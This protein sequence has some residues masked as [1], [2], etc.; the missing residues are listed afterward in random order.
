[1]TQEQK[2]QFT[3]RIAEANSTELVVILYEMAL[4][5][6]DDAKQAGESGA[7]ESFD[8]AVSRVRGCVNE[9]LQSLNLEYEIAQSLHSLY[10]FCL[11]RLAYAQVRRQT[12]VLDE[13]TMVMSGLRDAYAQIAP[14]NTGGPVMKNTQTVYA[15]LTYGRNS[16]TENMADQSTNRGMLV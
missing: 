4:C 14:Q 6:L 5:Y 9:L 3:L 11:R 7:H 10:F 15:G 8:G 16:L 1:M 13:V 12:Q 2:Q